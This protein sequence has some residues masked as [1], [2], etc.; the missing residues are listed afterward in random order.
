M[1][2]ANHLFLECQHFRQVHEV[3]GTQ[4]FQ[5]VLYRLLVLLNLVVLV[6][7]LLQQVQLIPEDPHHHWF[8]GFL[9]DPQLHLD[10]MDQVDLLDQ[11]NQVNLEVPEVLDHH[12]GQAILAYQHFLLDP[13]FLGHQQCLYHLLDQLVLKVPV[14]LNLLSI[15]LALVVQHYL[16]VQMVQRHLSAL[17]VQRAQQVQQVLADL[18]VQQDQQSLFHPLVPECLLILEYQ[19]VLLG[20]CLPCFLLLLVYQILPCHHLVHEVQQDPE[21]PVVQG[22]LQVPVVLADLMYLEF[23]I[24]QWVLL[25]LQ[26]QQDLGLLSVLVVQMAPVDLVVLRLLWDQHFLE[27]QLVQH[28]QLVLVVQ[29]QLDQVILEH[30]EDLFGPVVLVILQCHLVL[31][32][33]VALTVQG[34]QQFLCLP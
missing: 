11:L 32:Y 23:Q 33:H 17:L 6:I 15:H 27:Y 20:Q 28:H 21:I 10:L 13:G 26:V 7:L 5:L 22:L 2:L 31:N 14:D 24:I 3:L 9:W 30:P 19:M 12:F 16:Q 4:H 1:H 34:S 18:G 8:Q 25:V 29:R